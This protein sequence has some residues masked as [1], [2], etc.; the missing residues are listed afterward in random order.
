MVTLDLAG[1]TPWLIGFL[2]VAASSGLLAVA[3]VTDFVVRNRRTRVTRHQSVRSYYRG[4]ALT[5]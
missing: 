5:H 2:V 4:L 1:L 3:A